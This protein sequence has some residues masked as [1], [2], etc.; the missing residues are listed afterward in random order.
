MVYSVRERAILDRSDYTR[1]HLPVAALIAVLMDEVRGVF[2][3]A[4]LS[5]DRYICQAI[6]KESRAA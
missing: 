2:H 6:R 4:N 3:I 5:E 1:E